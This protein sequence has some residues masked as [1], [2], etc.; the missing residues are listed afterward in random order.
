MSF[1]EKGPHPDVDEGQR[2]SATRDRCRAD[3]AAA[4]ESLDGVRLDKLVS[5]V[6]RGVQDVFMTEA[7]NRRNELWPTN[8]RQLRLA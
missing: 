5:S 2:Y 3:V 8:L 6:R 1:P 7:S 4:L